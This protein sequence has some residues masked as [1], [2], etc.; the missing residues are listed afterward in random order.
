MTLSHPAITAA[1]R[2]HAYLRRPEPR[3]FPVEAPVPETLRHLELRTALY[4]S[5]RLELRGRA[6]VSSDQFVYWDPTD[7]EQC[8]AP[9]V[10]VR[11]GTPA[12]LL[13][14]WKTW[15]LGAPEL[16][17]E[18]VSEHDRPEQ[19]ETRKLERYRRAGVAEV[20]RFDTEHPT[21]KL[22]LFDLRGG[23][24][25]ERDLGAPDAF[26]CDTLGL[27][28]TVQEDA[29]LGPT[30]RLARDPSG[31]NLLPTPEEAMQAERTAKEA[32][33]AAK[34]EALLRVRELEAELSRRR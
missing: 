31:K 15:E 16:A 24:L 1:K 4:L 28:W 12:A 27:Y 6:T 9:D 7:P 32:E 8:L 5:I 26:H 23:D 25:V 18:I 10:A 14:V 2:E 29:E 3:H 33:R 22:R 20:V 30:L 21:A 11:L 17:V 13:D 19:Q 34:E